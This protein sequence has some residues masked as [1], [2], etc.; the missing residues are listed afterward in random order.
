MK[1]LNISALI[2][3]AG[4]SERMKFPKAFLMF[5]DKMT[6]LEKI[7]SEFK[8]FGCNSIFVVFNNKN[9]LHLNKNNLFL[10]EI[11]YGINYNPE[12]GR[13]SSLKIGFNKLIKNEFIFIHNIDNPFVEQ[14]TLELLFNNFSDC[15]F[16]VPTFQN[17]GGHPI[18][19]NQ[20]IAQQALEIPDDSNLKEFLNKFNRKNI[21]TNNRDILLNINTQDE[22][23]SIMKE[24]F[25]E[26]KLS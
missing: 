1:K 6:F 18:L 21:E 26:I 5:N 25:H 23:F 10:N 19:I 17:K 9:V 4:F 14:N 7:V 3:A 13:F 2:L 12:F 11:E 24:K 16:C 22:Y 8:I 15:D 20:N